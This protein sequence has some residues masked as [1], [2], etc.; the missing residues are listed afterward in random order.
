ME[1]EVQ[2]ESSS[3]SSNDSVSSGSKRRRSHTP[4]GTHRRSKQPTFTDSIIK[5]MPEIAH[6]ITMLTRDTAGNSPSKA[7]REASKILEAMWRAGEVGDNVFVMA[8]R[9]FQDSTK[10]EILINL[11]DRRIQMA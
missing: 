10:A 9:I 11:E 1:E 3:S 2:V 8:A 4:V 7:R 6:S 5:A